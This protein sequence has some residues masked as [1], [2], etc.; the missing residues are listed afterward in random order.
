MAGVLL[1]QGVDTEEAVQEA[2][3]NQRRSLRGKGSACISSADSL[4]WLTRVTSTAD[5]T[6]IAHLC[7]CI[8]GLSFCD[9]LCGLPYISALRR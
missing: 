4:T 7:L 6:V 8:V 3:G 2:T 1:T 9:S 5:G